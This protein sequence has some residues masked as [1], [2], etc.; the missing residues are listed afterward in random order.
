MTNVETY[1]TE[2]GRQQQKSEN[3]SV[4]IERRYNDLLQLAEGASDWQKEGIN[5]ATGALHKSHGELQQARSSLESSGN[6]NISNDSVTAPDHPIEFA[7]EGVAQENNTG[8]SQE[9]VSTLDE[10]F[11]N[12][13]YTSC[14]ATIHSAIDFEDGDNHRNSIYKIDG[15]Q[16]VKV[17]VKPRM[18]TSSDDTTISNGSENISDTSS[19]LSTCEELSACQQRK[20]SECPFQNNISGESRGKIV[21]A[22]GNHDR[23]YEQGL[24]AIQYSRSLDKSSD[25]MDYSEDAYDLRPPADATSE[26]AKIGVD[27]YPLPRADLD[28]QKE[29]DVLQ[30]TSTTIPQ[31]FV[32]QGHTEDDFNESLCPLQASSVH[33]VAEAERADEEDDESATSSDTSSFSDDDLDQRLTFD[34]ETLRPQR[35][36]VVPASMS[37]PTETS[38]TADID[39]R[40]GTPEQSPFTE[41]GLPLIPSQTTTIP[42]NDDETLLYD[43]LN[44]AKASKAAKIAKQEHTHHRRDSDVV[45]HALARNPLGDV[46]G[47]SPP[48]RD[49]NERSPIAS[50][51]LNLDLS[52]IVA[53]LARDG[54]A[55]GSPQRSK[56]R[57]KRTAK[58]RSTDGSISNKITND[59][60]QTQTEQTIAQAATPARFALRRH[61]DSRPVVLKKSEAQQVSQTTRNNTRRN[62]G[63]S[64]PVK[65]MLIRLQ[66]DEQVTET[67][68][69]S[70]PSEIGEGTTKHPR[71]SVRWNEDLVSFFEDHRDDV[72]GSLEPPDPGEKTPESRRRAALGAMNGTPARSRTKNVG[73]EDAGNQTKK[74]RKR[75]ATNEANADAPGQENA[76]PP[77]A[78][79]LPTPAKVRRSAQ[80]KDGGSGDE[81]GE[82]MSGAQVMEPAQKESTN[83]SVIA[84]AARQLP[85]RRRSGLPLR[86]GN[87]GEVKSGKG[88]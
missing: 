83:T 78:R 62:K 32:E 44:R 15:R 33:E 22:D 68:D 88:V 58:R 5:D 81:R 53:T 70:P 38:P 67:V 57:P 82:N 13:N 47:N 37:Q 41:L 86:G 46:D 48:Q 27:A 65:Q 66:S 54:A 56:R 30:E 49:P 34:I 77:K 3:L 51:T 2:H 9:F 31:S 8:N 55:S 72:F 17:G 14:K 74:G 24:D 85:R 10:P 6:D 63:A 71:R 36:A 26:D 75:A 60:A 73:A 23:A 39:V 64:V 52:P 19:T 7:K 1:V 80:V 11:H 40:V 59:D 28:S 16:S 61:P 20:G 35:H 42:L 79:R 69:V 76:K 45:K 43:F 25:D 18:E 50:P 87:D 84:T 4:T 12:A 21:A 29:T